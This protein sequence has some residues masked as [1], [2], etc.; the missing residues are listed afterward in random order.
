[1]TK[2]LRLAILDILK[3]HEPGIVDISK[4]VANL[5]GISGLNTV[6]YDVDKDVERIKVTIEGKDIP[7][8]KVISMI[9]K[10]GMSVHG[11]D[12]ISYGESVV[13]EV[14][15]PLDRWPHNSS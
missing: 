7:I 4:K 6:V 3:P 13:H 2:T 5:S 9:E 10:M 11:I 1:M 8:K 12:E 15:T 14:S